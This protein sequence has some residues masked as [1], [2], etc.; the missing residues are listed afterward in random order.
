[1][2]ELNDIQISYNERRKR[3][4]TIRIR[5]SHR[6]EELATV[7]EIVGARR[8]FGDMKCRDHVAVGEKLNMFDFETASRGKCY[9]IRLFNRVGALLN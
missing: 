7:M 4:R 6:R 8:D 1:M 3:F 5:T 2:I 9:S